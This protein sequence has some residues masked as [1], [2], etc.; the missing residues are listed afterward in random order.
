MLTAHPE[1]R[2]L[3]VETDQPTVG[4]ARA[5]QA[6]RRKGDILLA[7]FDGVPEFVG[8]LEDGTLAVAGMQQPYLIGQTCGRDMVDHL[9]G[10]ASQRMLQIPV[11]IVTAA[12]VKAKLSLIRE[13]VF[14]GT[15]G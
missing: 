11:E 9:S 4:A 13:T 1:M 10:K 12:N 14:A 3:F 8:M 2:A 7:G 15:A 5:I 6:T